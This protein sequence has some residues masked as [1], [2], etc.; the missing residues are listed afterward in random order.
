VLRPELGDCEEWV[1]AF[2]E[3]AHCLAV[4]SSD[5]IVRV[6]DA[7]RLDTGLPF[8]AMERLEG[9]DLRCV[10]DACGQMSPAVAVQYA[11]QACAA[12]SEVHENGLIHCDVKPANLFVTIGRDG[13]TRLKLLDFGIARPSGSVALFGR[14]PERSACSP[15]YASPEQ[16]DAPADLDCRT[17][18]WSLGLVLFEMLTGVCPFAAATVADTQRRIRSECAPGLSELRPQIDERLA[19]AVDTCL[20]KERARRFASVDELAA[21]L[22]AAAPRHFSAQ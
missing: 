17:D 7:G 4:L 15:L 16:L 14:S 18:I 11:L 5:H 12:L 13:A 21:A 3:E 10:M 2:L 20:Q 19:R 1:E 9:R 8:L 6:M 22:R